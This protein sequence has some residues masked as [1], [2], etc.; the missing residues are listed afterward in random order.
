[1]SRSATR[2]RLD[3]YNQ[4]KVHLWQ[5]AA[6]DLATSADHS[7]PLVQAGL[8]AVLAW[9]RTETTEPL[10]LLELFGRP[11]GPLGAQ[12]RLLGSLLLQPGHPPSGHAPKRCW[13]VAKAAYYARWLEL[14]EPPAAQSAPH[15]S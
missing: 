1:M 3:A 2:L 7:D 15:R 5:A 12:L 13:A 11:A 4:A 6:V 9:L 8:H 10:V 14:A